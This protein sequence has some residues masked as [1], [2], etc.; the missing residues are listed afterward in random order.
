M[1]A[2]AILFWEQ[3]ID[4]APIRPTLDPIQLTLYVSVATVA[5]WLLA[6]VL[7]YWPVALY[8]PYVAAAH[9]P[10]GVSAL[11]DQQIAAGIMWGPGSLAYS[12][13]VFW[14]I[15]NW[16]G[17]DNR[18]RRQETSP[19]RGRARERSLSEYRGHTQRRLGR[20]G[21]DTGGAAGAA[22]GRAAVGLDAAAARVLSRRRR[23]RRRTQ[24]SSRV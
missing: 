2:T 5:G 19:D 8:Q 23:G 10:G 20:R 24:V 17:D 22:G 16:V 4:T 12:L 7:A 21:T 9:R 18:G 6:A 1:L 14:L 3:V 13:A 15:Y 11:A